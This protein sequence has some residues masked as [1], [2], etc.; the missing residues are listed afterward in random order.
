MRDPKRIKAVLAAVER[1][2][3]ASP[4]LR[5]CQLILNIR[6]SWDDELSAAV[7]LEDLYPL[8]DDQLVQ[9]LQEHYRP[10]KA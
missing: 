4:D 1:I 7:D 5:L 8:E 9:R 6:K 10:P 3:Q 2:W